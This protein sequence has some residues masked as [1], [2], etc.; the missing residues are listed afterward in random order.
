MN[1]RDPF[2]D[3][4][5]RTSTPDDLTAIADT[6]R[7]LSA[8][9]LY[10]R[11]FTLLPDPTPFVARQLAQVDHFDHE[12]FVVLDGGDVVAVAQWDRSGGRPGVAEIAVTVAD[13]WQ[14]Q[15]LGRALVR[16]LAGSAHRLGIETLEA[17]VLTE[18]RAAVGLA[19]SQQ[20]AQVGVDGTET[21]YTFPLAS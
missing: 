17:S 21:H 2:P 10:Q 20:P 8:Q 11:F 1:G 5:L 14:H 4:V 6:Y 13:D 7:G 19:A 12:S 9:S 18:N 3:L 16:A 15:G